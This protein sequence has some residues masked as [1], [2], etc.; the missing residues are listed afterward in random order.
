MLRMRSLRSAPLALACWLGLAGPARREDG[1]ARI[2]M[3][4]GMPRRHARLLERVLRYL[5]RHFEIVPLEDLAAALAAGERLSRRIAITFDDGLRNN[6]EVAY[7]LLRALEVPATFFVCPQLIDEA[8]WLWNHEMRQRL[9]RLPSLAPVAA[10][11]RGPLGVEEFIEWMKKLDPARRREVEAQVRA[12]T[13]NFAATAAERDEFELAR[14]QDLRRLD[15]RLIA[16]GSH[17]L[18]H[19]ILP[20]LGADE[21]ERE[22]AQSRRLI[23]ERLQREVR[24][25]AYPNGDV[26]PAAYECVRRNYRA[27]VTVEEGCVAGGCD[28]HLLPRINVPGSVLR[29]ALA[30]GRAPQPSL[31]ILPGRNVTI[32]GNTQ[33]STTATTISAKNGSAARAI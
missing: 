10:T 6:V 32:P 11:S 19:P 16:I 21:M 26:D 13:P 28:P 15:A 27:A 22:V 4:H 33:I 24:L 5:K 31:N 30:L 25:F 29:L 14:W 2:L 20:T 23:E 9:R 12:A 17:T 18:T 8:R 1:R 7:P 3:L